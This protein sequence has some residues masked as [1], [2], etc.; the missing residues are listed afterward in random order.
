MLPFINSMIKSLSV[1]SFS[2]SL[3]L[4]TLTSGTANC[5]PCEALSNCRPGTGSKVR[6]KARA[7]SVSR[8]VQGTP[9]LCSALHMRALRFFSNTPKCDLRM[10]SASGGALP[11][12]SA[13]TERLSCKP[14]HAH[15]FG[16]KRRTMPSISVNKERGSSA[17]SRFSGSELL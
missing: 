16:S 4:R 7:C 17:L 14:E 12:S 11:A 15:P 2:S 3:A 9:E 8:S 6:I 13:C 1:S 10:V 5:T